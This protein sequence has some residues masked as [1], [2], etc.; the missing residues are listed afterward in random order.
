MLIL[1]FCFFFQTRIDLEACWTMRSIWPPHPHCFYRQPTP[2]VQWGN[3]KPTPA[4]QQKIAEFPNWP[5]Y[6]QTTLNSSL[7]HTKRQLMLFA[8][9]RDFRDVRSVFQIH[10]SCSLPC[11]GLSW[12]MGPTGFAS[13]IIFYM[14]SLWVE[15][16]L[17][18][19][20]PSDAERRWDC[21]TP[22]AQS[23]YPV[24]KSLV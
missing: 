13:L 22:R 4:D 23:C 3:G 8:Y 9:F 21:V 1:E 11:R 12:G 15:R 16:N 19:C 5:T 6:S 18:F 2:V 24:E 17:S 20:I 7:L 14:I 10:W